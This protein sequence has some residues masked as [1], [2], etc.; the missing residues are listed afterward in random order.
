MSLSFHLGTWVL[1]GSFALLALAKHTFGDGFAFSQEIALVLLFLCYLYSV[2]RVGLVDLAGLV[3]AIFS[4]VV[5][6]TIFVLGGFNT[7]PNLVNA[8]LICLVFMFV[9]QVAGV[10]GGKKAWRFGNYALVAVLILT[11]FGGISAGWDVSYL[12]DTRG[13]RLVAGWKKPTFLAEAA[14]LLIFIAVARHHDQGVTLL[15]IRRRVL[16]YLVVI[17][18]L[19]IVVS[20]GSRAALGAS[21]IFL[22]WMWQETRKSNS[23]RALKVL[24]NLVVFVSVFGFASYGINFEAL[25]A[26]SSGRW[27]MLVIETSAH[28]SEPVHWLFG[29]A[30]AHMIFLRN[31]FSNGSVYHIDSFFGERLIVTGFVGLFLLALGIWSFYSRMGAVG[32]AVILACLFYGIFENG[33]FNLTSMFSVFSL[34][35]AAISARRLREQDHGRQRRHLSQLQHS[36]A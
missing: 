30:D 4:T 27:N 24:I 3:L 28:L 17:G 21:A 14:T 33:V 34:L 5:F 7:V 9:G 25:N 31:E 18:L 36:V 6:C 16:F 20:T 12:G 11:L 22:Y 2:A 15:G 8:I 10:L 26:A 32:R 35:I 19:S 13:A 23:R 1:A 29:N